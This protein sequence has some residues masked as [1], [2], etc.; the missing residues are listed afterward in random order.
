MNLNEDPAFIAGSKDVTQGG[1][2]I[3]EADIDHATPNRDDNTLMD[4]LCHGV[5]L[6]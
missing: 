3:V 6:W 5:N 1:K 4:L 2:I